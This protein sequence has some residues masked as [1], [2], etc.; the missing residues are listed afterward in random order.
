MKNKIIRPKIPVTI[1]GASDG[2]AH[3]TPNVMGFM[4]KRDGVY[5]A[6]VNVGETVLVKTEN[7][8][9]TIVKTG[10]N[11]CKISGSEK[12]CPTPKNAYINGS[13]M[14]GSMIKSGFIGIG[15]NMEV[16][17]IDDELE[18]MK[19]CAAYYDSARKVGFTSGVIVS[20]EGKK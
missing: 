11:A 8:I 9:Y 12:F 20:V 1:T 15:M 18:K 7:T 3:F 2:S 19:S 4:D 10:D 13:T 16:L 6:D 17:W 5:F 14:G